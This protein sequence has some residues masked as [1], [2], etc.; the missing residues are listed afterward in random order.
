MEASR[1]VLACVFLLIFG[2]RV[3]R[4][5]LSHKAEAY[6]ASAADDHITFVENARAFS[7]FFFNARVMKPVGT[8]DPST[9]ILGFKSSIPVFVSGAALAKLGHP[10]GTWLMFL[11][12]HEFISF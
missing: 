1:S 11:L 7:R 5:V 2:K 10:L 4:N 8:C 6:Y 3:A 12:H 9:T